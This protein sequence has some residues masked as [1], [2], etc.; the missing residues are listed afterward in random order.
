MRRL[1]PAEIRAN[2]E[3][4]RELG[5]TMT[6][7]HYPLHLLALELADQY[8]IVVWDEVPVYQMADSLSGAAR[9]AQQPRHGARW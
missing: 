9:A 4:L 6:R 8:G 7:S 5:A 1:G 3:L 2:F